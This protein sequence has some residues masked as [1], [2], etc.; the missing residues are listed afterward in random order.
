MERKKAVTLALVVAFLVCTLVVFLMLRTKPA[1]SKAGTEAN[2][3]A[4]VSVVDNMTADDLND[5]LAR[6]RQVTEE[7]IISI[8]ETMPR[9]T[10]ER[11]KLV[12][13]GTGSVEMMTALANVLEERDLKNSSFFFTEG[14]MRSSQNAIEVLL[15]HD[16]EVGLM[17]DNQGGSMSGTS[18]E[19]L[20]ASLCSL[21]FLFRAGYNLIRVPVMS[22]ER[23]SVTALRA[24][25]ACGF[26]EVVVT[27][28]EISLDDCTSV[29]IS[30]QLLFAVDRGDIVRVHL[31]GDNSE[32]VV[33][34]LTA[35]LDALAE[36]NS[37]LKAQQRLAVWSTDWGLAYPIRRIDTT[38]EGAMFTFTGLGN[39]AELENVLQ[40]LRSLSGK[41]LFYVT[42]DEAVHA[43]DRVRM[44]LAEG[45]NIGIYVP[46][47][48]SPTAEEYLTEMISC[49]EE[50]R[51]QFG[52][53]NELPVYVPYD[54]EFNLLKA[55]SAGGFSLATAYLFPVRPQDT[56]KVD[57]EEEIML[58][59]LSRFDR[60]V[61]RGELVH[62]DLNQF[63]YSDEMSGKLIKCFAEQRCVYPLHTYHAMFNN[64]PK[65]W[66][67]PLAQNDVITS[68]RGR[69]RRGQ[70]RT[71]LMTEMTTHY[72]GSPWIADPLSMTEFTEQEIKTIDKTGI[73]KSNRNEVYLTFNDADMDAFV[74]PLL[75]VLKKH[76]AKATFF[77]R[78]ETADWNPNLYRAIAEEGHA[79]AIRA[80]TT[81]S[82]VYTSTYS[83]TSNDI[84]RNREVAIRTLQDEFKLAYDTLVNI[85]GD[86]RLSDGLPAVTNFFRPTLDEINPIGMSAA[87]DSGFS[88][89]VGG[90]YLNVDPVIPIPTSLADD[91]EKYWVY[92]DGQ[93]SE[94]I[95]ATKPG[96]IL[97]ISYIIDEMVDLP[98]LIDI[99]LTNVEGKY[100]FVPLTSVLA[101]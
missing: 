79:L 89:S 40:T 61:N 56:R 82:D 37:R 57:D 23:P 38:E 84:M 29:D 13:T 36:T 71:S 10:G 73:I 27:H 66:K 95:A 18:G 78:T 76:N 4:L 21:S 72:I 44:V 86:I 96:A 58:D 101:Q 6:F 70:L 85:A 12:F 26:S 22:R 81:F 39:Q 46:D 59:I 45:H 68:I 55:A 49:D 35:L 33:T 8:S 43:R 75:H 15:D 2:T 47:I 51:M 67:Y 30:R 99:Y 94:M 97:S 19:E 69:I 53:S 34:N 92:R 74:T 100:R 87:F 7:D 90:N 41:G 48:D 77:I 28:S 63:I 24:A 9:F 52:Y 98:T 17:Y 5:A 32:K 93:L 16:I 20:V 25:T 42:L 64:T 65:L 80:D 83:M 14:E 88:W 3:R 62:F 91:A 11:V 60:T 1:A 50:I 54:Q 31:D